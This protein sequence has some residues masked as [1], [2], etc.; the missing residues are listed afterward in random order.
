MGLQELIQPK[1]SSHY[2]SIRESGWVLKTGC[3]IA[4]GDSLIVRGGVRRSGSDLVS[5]GPAPNL[6]AK[7][8]DVRENPFHIRIGAATYKKLSA[9]GRLS[10]GKNMWQG[11]YDMS[12]GGKTYPYYRTSYYWKI[13]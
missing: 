8:S 12:L 1:I 2:K 10:E 4:S 11:T 6:A 9:S 5:I 13:P 3:G 7:L